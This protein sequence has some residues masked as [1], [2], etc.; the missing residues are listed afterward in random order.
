MIGVFAIPNPCKS[1]TALLQ[2]STIIASLHR[3]LSG[4]LASKPSK[5]NLARNVGTPEGF[6]SR[7][8]DFG[9]YCSSNSCDHLCSC[10]PCLIQ[11]SSVYF[12]SLMF[13]HLALRYLDRL[14][15]GDRNF[16]ILGS[17][18][19]RYDLSVTSSTAC[20]STVGSWTLS[21]LW[22]SFHG[23]I[24]FKKLFLRNPTISI[25]TEEW[26]EAESG[27]AVRSPPKKPSLAAT[28]VKSIIIINVR[29]I[30]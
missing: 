9:E 3:C 23:S 21:P 30:W 11:T 6:E 22:H 28:K 2:L 20:H 17:L 1:M 14:W 5:A 10:F 13:V 16:E 27:P 19:T 15:S 24:V 7:R 4:K 12:L 29:I 25:S 8:W 18:L 26:S